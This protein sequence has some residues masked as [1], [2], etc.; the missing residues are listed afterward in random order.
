[1]KIF[2][3]FIVLLL[4]AIAIVSLILQMIIYATHDI[5]T[6][7]ASPLGY[8]LLRCVRLYLEVDMYAAFE[9]HTANT[10]SEGRS[11]VQALTAFMKVSLIML[12][13]TK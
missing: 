1:M 12:Y 13:S 8:L 2:Q 5:L 3:R 10:I 9:V 7:E 11:A 6:E 4:R